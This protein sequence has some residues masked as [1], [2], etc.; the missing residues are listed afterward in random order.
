M[1][2]VLKTAEEMMVPTYQPAGEVSNL[3]YT[4]IRP[5]DRSTETTANDGLAN[6]FNNGTGLIRSFFRPSD[7]STIYQGLIPSNMM[8]SRYLEATAPIMSAIGQDATAQKMSD[9]AASL[10]AAIEK[11]AIVDAPG[12]GK[13]YA[14]E[15]DGTSHLSWPW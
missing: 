12:Y 1:E 13:I 15:V 9:L 8:F 5:T 7:D 14:F 3:T 4:F 2:T 6:P 10:K 11:W